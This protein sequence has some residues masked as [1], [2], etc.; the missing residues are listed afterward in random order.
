MGKKITDAQVAKALGWKYEKEF[1]NKKLK[2]RVPAGWETPEGRVHAFVPH[3]TTDLNVITAEITRL[4]LRWTYSSRMGAGTVGP[5]DHRG[6][7]TAFVNS[8]PMALCE[9]LVNY[10]KGVKAN[11]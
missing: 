7:R 11:G 4:D 1:W 6:I 9:A 2:Y 10:L 8:A 5:Q 3:F